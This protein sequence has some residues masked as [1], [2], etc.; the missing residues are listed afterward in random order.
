MEADPTQEQ[1]RVTTFCNRIKKED[2]KPG[3][4][5]Y[6]HER[7]GFTNKHGIYIGDEKV[8]F[9]CCIESKIVKATLETFSGGKNI[10][11]ALYNQQTTRTLFRRKGTTFTDISKMEHDVI[12]SAKLYL[13][14]PD[15]WTAPLFGNKSETFARCCKLYPLPVDQQ[16]L[17]P[18]DHICIERKRGLYTHHG[19]YAK[20]G[21]VVH[22]TGRWKCSCKIKAES[23]EE[24]QKQDAGQLF[25]FTRRSVAVKLPETGQLIQIARRDIDSLIKCAKYFAENPEEWR[26]YHAIENNCELFCIW[27]TLG[28]KYPAQLLQHQARKLFILFG[29]KYKKS[30]HILDILEDYA[31]KHILVPNDDLL[32]NISDSLK[33]HTCA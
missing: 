18:G 28:A 33:L 8:I 32:D 29:R 25:R 27:V 21:E 17:E 3:D 16:D 10:R 6:I 15:K 31:N 20:Q 24:F 30:K 1:T 2:L 19:I 7:S 23:L 4:H 26:R 14:N 12:D 13:E 11:L 5:I 22:F 9:Y